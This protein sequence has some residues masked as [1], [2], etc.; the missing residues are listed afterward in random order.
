MRWWSPGPDYIIEVEDEM[1]VLMDPEDEVLWSQADVFKS[2]AEFQEQLLKK[3]L[4]K[5]ITYTSSIKQVQVD[6]IEEDHLL[7]ISIV[8]CGEDTRNLGII[9]SL[10]T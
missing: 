4:L 8:R 10:F 9:D 3:R 2:D 5:Y 1:E 6:G 7:G